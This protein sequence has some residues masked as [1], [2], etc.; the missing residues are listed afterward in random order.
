MEVPLTRV[1]SARTS[2][3]PSHP[4]HP[5]VPP[6]RHWCTPLPVFCFRTLVGVN[7]L[8]R[9]S[10]WSPTNHLPL[11]VHSKGDPRL[12]GWRKRTHFANSS[13]YSATPPPQKKRYGV[14]NLR[15]CF[16]EQGANLRY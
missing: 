10:S 8:Y 12:G 11:Q 16:N 15:G 7:L 3:L 4:N 9:D 2:E 14:W 6:P 13:K 1:M 5:R